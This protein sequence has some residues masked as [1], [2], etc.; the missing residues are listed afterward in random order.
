MSG[1]RLQKINASASPIPKWM[2]KLQKKRGRWWRDYR[3][4]GAVKTFV[5]PEHGN[6]Y[7]NVLK[8]Q[9]K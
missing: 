4:G 5:C 8:Q 2:W 9:N 6:N 7:I 3:V 1:Y